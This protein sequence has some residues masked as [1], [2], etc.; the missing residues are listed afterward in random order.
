MNNQ[1]RTCLA[2]A[3]QDLVVNNLDTIK[4]DCF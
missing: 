3:S 4:K 1:I 2:N